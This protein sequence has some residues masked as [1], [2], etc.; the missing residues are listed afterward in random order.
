MERLV[1]FDADLPFIGPG[2]AAVDDFDIGE[3]QK[4]AFG[5]NLDWRRDAAAI[6]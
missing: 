1:E 6:R 2:D 4:H 5:L 3:A